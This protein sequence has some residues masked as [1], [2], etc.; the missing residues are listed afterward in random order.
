ME[1]LKKEF[2]DEI[3]EVKLRIDNIKI[4]FANYYSY[5]VVRNL[6]RD[7]NLK[8]IGGNIKGNDCR[9]LNVIIESNSHAFIYRSYTHIE[10]INA[11]ASNG[12]KKNITLNQ[13]YAD[14]MR[15]NKED[16]N[17]ERDMEQF[18]NL[19]KKFEEIKNSDVKQRVLKFRNKNF[20]HIEKT[21]EL[22][23][24]HFKE[25][26]EFIKKLDDNFNE[27][28]DYFQITFFPSFDARYKEI[29]ISPQKLD[30]LVFDYT[31]QWLKHVLFY[32]Y[33]GELH[34]NIIEAVEK[35]WDIVKKKTIEFLEI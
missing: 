24:V 5:S 25:L 27:L 15:E 8:D 14:F 34:Q 9:I 3:E 18:R 2:L 23:K 19:K 33:E 13:I 1:E 32:V 26:F 7:N 4:A 16:S 30:R 22:E 28:L 20:A 31:H 6:F 29:P 12:G 21:S 11:F 17:S 35:N 10:L